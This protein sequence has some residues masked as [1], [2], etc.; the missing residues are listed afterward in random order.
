MTMILELVLTVTSVTGAAV[1]VVVSRRHVVAAETHAA[2]AAEALAEVRGLAADLQDLTA[3]VNGA[4]AEVEW[5]HVQQVNTHLSQLGWHRDANAREARL[6]EWQQALLGRGRMPVMSVAELNEQFNALAERI[7][8]L[9]AH[10]DD[11]PTVETPAHLVAVYDGQP[12]HYTSDAMPADLSAALEQALIQRGLDPED[13]IADGMPGTEDELGPDTT[14][15]EPVDT[16][17]TAGGGDDRDDDDAVT[18]P[19]TKMGAQPQPGTGPTP[20]THQPLP[21]PP[22]PRALVI[23]HNLLDLMADQEEQALAELVRRGEAPVTA[24]AR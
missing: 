3:R 17:P 10:V 1:A 14:A 4:V 13:V 19:P 5:R 9:S 22:K 6:A 23:R 7:G 24:G 18:L 11:E 15:D 21:Q 2:D 16:E 20:D 8:P 12:G